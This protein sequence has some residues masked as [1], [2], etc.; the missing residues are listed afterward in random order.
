LAVPVKVEVCVPAASLT[1]T[2]AVLTPAGFGAA[3][4]AKRTAIE[5]DA[6]GARVV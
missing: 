2:V 5:H 4:G 6:P 3:V 1:D